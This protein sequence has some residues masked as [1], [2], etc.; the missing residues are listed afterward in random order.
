MTKK[1]KITLSYLIIFISIIIAFLI[2]GRDAIF[3]DTLFTDVNFTYFFMFM[4][5]VS[6]VLY[7]KPKSKIMKKNQSNN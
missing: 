7:Y 5:P 3:G 6:A 2:V 4:I 1:I